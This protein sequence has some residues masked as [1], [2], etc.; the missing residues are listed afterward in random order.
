M[1]LSSWNVKVNN[2]DVIASIKMQKKMQI[3]QE[4]KSHKLSFWELQLVWVK[5]S[6]RNLNELIESLLAGGSWKQEK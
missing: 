2:S 6:G 5:K 1:S 4:N 3:F